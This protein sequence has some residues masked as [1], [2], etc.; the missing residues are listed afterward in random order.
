AELVE[1]TTEV[2][3]QTA[4]AAAREAARDAANQEILRAIQA[5]DGTHQLIQQLST[6]VDDLRR[7]LS[8]KAAAAEPIDSALREEYVE[9]AAIAS[10][11]LL[12]EAQV[13]RVIDRMLADAGWAVQ[14]RVA[15]N[16]HA[17]QGVAV[18]EV[19]VASGRADYLLYVDTKLVGVI[20]AKREGA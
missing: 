10:R 5:R 14:D 3:E 1:M 11:P 20:E 2:G 19:P 17:A 9:R 6:K 4:E 7:Q 18:R 15:T 12:T 16:V 8:T 13:R